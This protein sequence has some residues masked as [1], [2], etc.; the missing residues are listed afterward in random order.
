[1]IHAHV[2]DFLLVSMLI[3]LIKN[4]MGDVTDSN[5]YRSIAISSLIMKLYDLVI[6]QLFKENLYFDEL[7]FGYQ[8]EVSTTMC[9]WLASETISYFLRNGS[10]VFSCLMDMSKAFDTVQ[11]S[12]LFK[13]LLDQGFPPI[14]VRFLLASYRDQQANVRWNDELSRYFG[15]T[16]GVKQGAIL[17]SI[18]YCVYT[19]G[20]FEELRRRKVGCFVGSTYVGVIGYAD[21][22]FLMSPSLDGLQEM[23]K[24][25]EEYAN[26]HNLKFSTDANPQKSKTK[27]MAFLQKDRE[28]RGMRLCDNTLPWVGS[29]KRLGMCIENIWNILAKI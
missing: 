17:S 29:G 21:D 27:C 8:A 26:D 5:S 4:K 3:P 25:C 9:T 14:V 19:N 12:C 16:N 18:L 13:K 1:M 23:L 2:S 15:I 10:E 24:V 6:I 28:L 7:Q 22:L 11:H 20:L